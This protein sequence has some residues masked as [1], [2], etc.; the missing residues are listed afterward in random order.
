[1]KMVGRTNVNNVD[2]RIGCQFLERV[3]GAFKFERRS[4]GLRP[5]RRTPESAEHWNA[6]PPK[7]I[8]V[9]AS[10]KSRADNCSLQL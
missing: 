8:N 2:L 6:Q 1:M 5:F 10:Y 7:S 4:R 3:V 9:S